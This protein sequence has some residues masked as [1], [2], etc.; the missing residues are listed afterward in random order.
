MTAI[1]NA[2]SNMIPAVSADVD[3]LKIALFCG[4]GLFASLLMASSYGLDMS[5]GFF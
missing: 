3:F 1:A 5:G 4:T 2:I